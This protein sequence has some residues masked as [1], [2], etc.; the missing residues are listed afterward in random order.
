MA[1]GA[2]SDLIQHP[3][4]N[5]APSE[6]V[7]ARWIYAATAVGFIVITLAGFIPDSL[8]K[9]IAVE[10]GKRPPFP[11]IL[12]L[13]AL[14]MGSFLLL[15][16]AQTTLVAFGRRDL[17][18]RLWLAAFVI[19]PA[20]VVVGFLLAPTMYH[21]AWNAAQHAPP[22]LREEMRAGL[23]RRDNNVLTQ[24][25]ISAEIGTPVYFCQIIDFA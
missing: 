2:A 8:S 15:L 3:K 5:I 17:R 12:H 10:A 25:W 6:S 19:V 9:I 16:A 4:L 22:K 1:A 11:P 24:L 23:L 14:L 21:F 7:I 20:L 18:R 13:H